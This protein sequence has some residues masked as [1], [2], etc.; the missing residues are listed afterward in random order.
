MVAPCHSS[1][2]SGYQLLLAPTLSILNTVLDSCLP[3]FPR[4][5]L[6]FLP[7]H[8]DAAYLSLA[9]SSHSGPA[10]GFS[11]VRVPCERP[12]TCI[13]V[14]VYSINRETTRGAAFLGEATIPIETIGLTHV[15]V[16]YGIFGDARV[17]E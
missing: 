2:C 14:I 15:T 16:S 13:P 6:G 4:V 12:R 8:N 1:I 3:E 9:L 11:A 17:G 10:R 7:M 5:R